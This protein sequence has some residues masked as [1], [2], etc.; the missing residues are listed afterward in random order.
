MIM[1]SGIQE[2]PPSS[3]SGTRGLKPLSQSQSAPRKSLLTRIRPR[4][5]RTRLTLWYLCVLALVLLVFIAGT[6]LIQFY[7]LRSQLDRHAIQ[8][9]ETVE[10]LLYFT[11]SGQLNVRED[12]HN[13]PESRQVQER[14]LELLSPEG[15]ILYR[16]SRLGSRALGS[17][18]FAGEGVGGY[19]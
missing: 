16:N 13:H 12:Y 17:T 9:L 2:K 11:S 8:D 4:H 10:G 7:Q 19:F 5:V 6:S 14:M 18:P 15:L 1:P 3:V